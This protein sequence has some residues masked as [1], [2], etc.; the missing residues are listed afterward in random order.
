M[1]LERDFGFFRAT[2]TLDKRAKRAHFA[3]SAL[4]LLC[5]ISTTP[6]IS[7]TLARAD[8][9]GIQEAALIKR[10][11]FEEDYSFLKDP[12]KHVDYLDPLKFIPLNADSNVF[13]SLGGSIRER[14]EYF[15][16]YKWGSGTQTYRPYLLQRY[17]AHT[18]L[19]LGSDFRFFGELKSGLEG[20]RDGGPRPVDVDE[21]DVSQAFLE[22]SHSYAEQKV[23]L[24]L[25]RQEYRYGSCRLIAN[26]DEAN[27]Q[28]S[29]DGLTAIVNQ[30]KW[31]ID[32]FYGRLVNTNTGV[33]DDSA[34]LNTVLWGAYVTGPLSAINTHLDLYYLGLLRNPIQFIKATA[35][36]ERHT[37]G[38]RVW[39]T[40]EP[41]D[42]DTE[43]LYQFG[44]FG[45]GTIGAWE[46]AT[47]TGYTFTSTAL[48][49]RLG[50]KTNF[51]SGDTDP[52]SSDTGT[53]DPIFPR[54]AYFD[55]MDLT[56]PSNIISVDPNLALKLNSKFTLKTDWDWF[57]RTSIY[58]GIYN[59]A[60]TIL[61]SGASSRARYVGNA[62]GAKLIWQID[63]HTMT[64]LTYVHYF[65]GSFIE[66]SGVDGS[67]NYIA[68]TGSYKF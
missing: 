55:Q 12:S 44:S 23:A 3:I 47:D 50:L 19:H 11:R 34:N 33:F 51:A 31:Q 2:M 58:D 48:T 30:N 57:W 8:E 17:I 67:I 7:L 37:V 10:L 53:F 13:L 52:K 49:P 18:D 36:E 25:G 1:L 45:S 65:A 21:L 5:V 16:N 6:L 29:L 40:S 43:F 24:R 4:F 68:L 41:I 32:G 27:V 14:A 60:L 54:G 63:R 26:R 28:R 39:D 61:R 22:W 66:Q 64:Y 9:E 42:Y 56:G 59:N 15:Q 62:P 20:G 35:N 46:L 38:L